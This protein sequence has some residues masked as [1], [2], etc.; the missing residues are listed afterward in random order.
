M[1]VL[2]YAIR[3][4]PFVFDDA[5]VFFRYALNLR[6]GLGL[7]WNP[8]G[9][10]TYGMPGQLWVFVVLPFTYLPFAADTLLRMA[11]W[12]TG[13]AALLMLALIIARHSRSR[14]LQFPPLALAAVAVPLLLNPR[15]F[16]HLTSGM[17]TM[18]SLLA[19]ALLI[20]AILNYIRR[21]STGRAVLMGVAGFLTVAARPDNAL[22]AAAAP[23][24]VWACVP[25]SN[26]WT[27]A[28][29]FVITLAML[30][31]LDAALCERY[32]GIAL[33]MSLPWRSLPAFAG[34]MSTENSVAYAFTA[35]LCVLPFIGVLAATRTR[36]NNA[37]GDNTLTRGDKESVRGDH[38][39]VA[40]V[41][42]FALLLPAAATLLCL[43]CARQ[44]MGFQGR[45][46]VPFIPFVVVPALLCLDAGLV[47][48]ARETL[49]RAALGCAAAFV[50]F[51]LSVPL[52]H[53]LERGY[54]SRVMPRAIAVPSLTTTARVPLPATEWIATIKAVG[55][56]AS[57]LPAATVVAAA[58]VGYLGAAASDTTIMDL[59]GINDAAAARGLP[60]DRLLD[61][62]PD[63]LWLPPRDYTGLRAALLSDPR[64]SAGYEVIAGAF[65]SAIAIRR[66]GAHHA[67]VEAEVARAWNALYPGFAM[68]DYVARAAAGSGGST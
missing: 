18:L 52:Q 25:G 64:L 23:L 10:P 36:G 30:A 67:E 17:D 59:T 1:A 14:Y 58:E 46:Y 35:T 50:V 62:A 42:T 45:Y 26:R 49:L 11:S 7:A 66:N 48:H 13:E 5:Y 40:K 20:L 2:P 43:L 3:R 6:H 32:F 16:Y 56:I 34:F 44:H 57:R 29:G 38:V 24:L 47:G 65:N 55:Q 68:Q 19:N 61:R 54:L 41:T 12:L 33:S 27:D 53:W 51:G 60:L 39:R 21:P 22:C 9:L 4:L 28:A 8:D 63:L 15:F 31:G 37:R